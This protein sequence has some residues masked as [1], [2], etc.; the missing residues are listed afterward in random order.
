MGLAPVPTPAFTIL[1]DL[2]P[3]AIAHAI[4]AWFYDAEGYLR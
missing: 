1:E 4:D 3:V 2:S